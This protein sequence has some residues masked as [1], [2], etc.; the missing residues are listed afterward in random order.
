MREIDA[1]GNQLA[2]RTQKGEDKQGPSRQDEPARGV[3]A[4]RGAAPAPPRGRFPA[5]EGRFSFF[6]AES[7]LAQC[8]ESR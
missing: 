5:R 6:R 8:A 4:P 2:N 7:S 1:E 3:R